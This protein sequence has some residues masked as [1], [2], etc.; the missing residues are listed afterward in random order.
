MEN[1]FEADPW[2]VGEFVEYF[3]WRVTRIRILNFSHGRGT[4]IW[5]TD[6]RQCPFISPFAEKIDWVRQQH[7]LAFFRLLTSQSGKAV[8]RPGRLLL[9]LLTSRQTE[10]PCQ[11]R[12]PWGLLS[13]GHVLLMYGF[14]PTKWHKSES[15]HLRMNLTARRAPY[16]TKSCSEDSPDHNLLANASAL[17]G[18]GIGKDS[19]WI[20]ESRPH[21]L[22][23]F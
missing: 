19:A 22:L 21:A 15:G 8:P 11:Q 20:T 16:T 2:S 5:R 12:L 10:A 13:T 1:G 6:I 14:S 9:V 23:E 7:I 3:E 17:E 4:W 18:K